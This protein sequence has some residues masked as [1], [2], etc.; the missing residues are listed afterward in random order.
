MTAA[1]NDGKVGIVLLKVGVR[2]QSQQS[3]ELS[4]VSNWGN[5]LFSTDRDIPLC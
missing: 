1:L 5:K 3:L 4:N 2:L